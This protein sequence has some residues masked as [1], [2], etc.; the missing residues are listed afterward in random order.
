M[1]RLL[2]VA[3]AAIG[4]V[5]AV[6]SAQETVA[7]IVNVTV[8]PMD[9]EHTLPDRTVVVRG[10]RIVEIGPTGAVR[11][12]AGAQR[13]EG[14]GRFLIPG[15]AEMHAHIPGGQASPD[16]V[17][18]V[19]F[20]YVANG[21]TTIRG[22]LGAPAHRVLRAQAESGSILSPRIVTS[23]P[24]FNGTT[25]PTPD[26]ARRMVEEQ[27]A[28]GYDFLKI[29]P[30]LTRAV[31][32]TLAAT[33]DRVGIRFAGHVPLEVGLDRA[34]AA[35][36][37]T[38]DHLDG[39]PEWLAGLPPGENGGFFG[40]GVADRIVEERI[41]EIALRTRT[42]EVWVVPTETLLE[43]VASDETAE[44]MAARPGME[45]LPEAMVRSWMST[46]NGWRSGTPAAPESRHRYLAA[47]RRL[48]R[49]LHA[50]GAGILLGS[51]APQVGNVPGFSVHA[52]L[53]SYVAAG[54][55]P[56]EALRTGTVNVARFL[57][58]DRES[59]TVAVGRRADL[60]LLEADP[61]ADIRNTRR[62][63]GVMAGGRWL[64][65]Q[66]I[67]ARLAALRR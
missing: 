25:A 16:L 15:L 35:R 18:R 10:G 8:V 23:G 24:S 17:E 62:I 54:L 42:A 4:L 31:F 32:D 7:A 36:Y 29:H 14:R 38:I 20:L 47:R 64:D 1:R 66:A 19:L 21:V 9:R 56:F 65:A 55:T 63:A 41:A 46:L 12:P 67:E 52:E 2:V 22:M 37:A 45:Y 28:A 50:A 51:D 26:V 33:A 59:G 48:L 13:I 27:R 44:Q 53:A 5:P 34:L 6:A 60:V 49:E 57:G 61:L 30:G 39:F 11:I 40:L 43:T 3:A 58:R